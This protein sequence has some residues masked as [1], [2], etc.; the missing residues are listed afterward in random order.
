MTTFTLRLPEADY[1]A[2]QAM[3]LLLGKSMSELARDAIADK[4]D[5]FAQSKDAR[6]RLEED[7]ERRRQAAKRILD[8]T[9]S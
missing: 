7:I 1:E 9:S 2:L 5:R 3:A 8:R 4:V 6:E